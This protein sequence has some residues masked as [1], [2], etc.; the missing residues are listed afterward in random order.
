MSEARAEVVQIAPMP[1]PTGERLAERFTVH[2]Y[3]EAANAEAFLAGPGGQAPAIATLG[4]VTIEKALIPG[5]P[6]LRIVSCYGVGVDGVDLAAAKAKGVIVTNTPDVL[7]DCVADLGISLLL[8]ISRRLVEADRYVRSG[9]WLKAEFKLTAAPRGK[10][11]GIV[12]LGRIGLAV[13]RR[14]EAFGM[15]IA[16]HNRGKRAEVAYPYYATAAALAAASDYLLLTCPG[17]AATRHLVD[18]KVLEALGP[19]GY[20]INVARGSVVDEAALVEALQHRRIAGAGLDVFADE[21]RAPA[22]LFALDNVV[23]T[24]HIASATLETRTAMGDLMIENLRRYFDGEQVLT[25]VA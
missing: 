7:T 20:L 17:G 3:W 13:A 1:S 4:N 9:Q 12:G 22:A 16:Y 15:K 8:M 24:P 2:R 5:M 23:L 18:A 25:R 11:L 14:A 21:P 6:K 10:T 19:K